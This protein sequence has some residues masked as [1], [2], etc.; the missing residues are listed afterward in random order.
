MRTLKTAI[1]LLLALAAPLAAPLTAHAAPTPA[2]QEEINYL[3]SYIEK[4]GCEFYR[5]GSW[6]D[7]KTAQGHMRTKYDY[8]AGRDYVASVSDFIAKAASESSLTGSPYQVR[9][10]QNQPVLSRVWLTEELA[11]H[12]AQR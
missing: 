5:N 6:S 7:A 3:L 2:V 11:R 10:G 12:Q 9:C 8:L 4:S 1:P